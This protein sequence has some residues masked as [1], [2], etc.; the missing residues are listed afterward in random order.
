[1]STREA[2]KLQER[3]PDLLREETAYRER[4]VEREAAGTLNAEAR[5][6]LE[7]QS[8]ARGAALASTQTLVTRQLATAGPL[9]QNMARG[10]NAAAVG[11][12]ALGKALSFGLRLL[13]AIGI[14]FVVLQGIGSIIGVDVFGK[15]REF[16]EY[17]FDASAAFKTGQE[18][19]AKVFDDQATNIRKVTRAQIDAKVALADDKGTTP[20]VDADTIEDLQRQLTTAKNQKQQLNSSVFTPVA[21]D[22]QFGI[23]AA[24]AA[25]D[26]A[27]F[28]AANGDLIRQAGEG[29]AKLLELKEEFDKRY[30]LSSVFTLNL[31]KSQAGKKSAQAAI[32]KAKD[33]LKIYEALSK[34]Y[35]RLTKKNEA[36]IGDIADTNDRALALAGGDQE[37]LDK[38]TDLVNDRVA[39]L[40]ARIAKLTE[41]VEL[42]TNLRDIVEISGALE[43][44]LETANPLLNDMFNAKVVGDADA[45][46]A[47]LGRLEITVNGVTKTLATLNKEGFIPKDQEQRVQDALIGMDMLLK[48]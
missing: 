42:T 10:L 5:G 33:E 40:E 19:L 34:E 25:A 26:V 23:L 16:Y 12:A 30:G 48:N 9:A 17:L 13:N 45:I 44:S 39:D 27:A 29:Q 15:A 36:Y 24:Q 6:R 14:A 20:N 4:L 35:E 3:I 32:Q 38:T 28:E 1:M 8:V 18:S 41:V 21:D 11:A 2:V 47:G 22:S 46:A 37:L 7:A 31:F 43:N